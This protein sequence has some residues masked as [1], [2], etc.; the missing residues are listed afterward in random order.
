[1]R[2]FER[3]TTLR[4]PFKVGVSVE[5]ANSQDDA[6]PHLENLGVLGTEKS[7]DFCVKIA[8]AE[9]LDEAQCRRCLS[10][11]LVGERP[12]GAIFPRRCS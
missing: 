11:A 12:F 4:D 3:R 7:E 9:I 2:G 6:L 1:M 5:Q 8:S 10:R